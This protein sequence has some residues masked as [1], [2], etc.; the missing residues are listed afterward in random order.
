MFV[1]REDASIVSENP[2]QSIA[3]ADRRQH[4]RYSC[5]G[6]AEVFVIGKGLRFK[7]RIADLSEAGCYIET[8]HQL[9]RGT[10]LELTFEVNGM[11]F[12]LTGG[13]RVVHMHAGI[14]IA[15]DNMNERRRLFVQDLIEELA[16]QEKL[17]LEKE[18]ETKAD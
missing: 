6:T 3:N 7:G 14:G 1:D 11:R 9:E 17:R 8:P 4:P 10:H 16:Q 18:Q 15:F 12:R 2:A 5:D 13:I